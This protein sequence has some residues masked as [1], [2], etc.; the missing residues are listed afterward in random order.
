MVVVDAAV[1]ETYRF[2]VDARLKVLRA[3]EVLTEV[4][5]LREPIKLCDTSVLD[6]RL[7]GEG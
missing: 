2:A 4:T 5:P 1:A 3:G 6:D 7:P